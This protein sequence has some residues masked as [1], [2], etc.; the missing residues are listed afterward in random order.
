MVSIP[1]RNGRLPLS[2]STSCGTDQC[3]L[4]RLCN[5]AAITISTI[6]LCG[7][8]FSPIHYHSFRPKSLNRISRLSLLSTYADAN[9]HLCLLSPLRSRLVS[10]AANQCPDRKK[11]R[12]A[13][14]RCS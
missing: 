3:V 4:L 5:P 9:F 13:A 8:C 14:C 6:L 7:L 11:S 12:Q 1:V 2:A 10:R